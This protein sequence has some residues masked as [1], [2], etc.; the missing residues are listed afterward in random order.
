MF[1][2]E[3]TMKKFK[4]VITSDNDLAIDELW[5]DGNA[6]ENPTVE[7]VHYLISTLTFSPASLI[8]DWNLDYD[9]DIQEV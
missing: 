6:P 4:I 1:Q 9:L 2:Q 5:P 3:T 7:D 8:C